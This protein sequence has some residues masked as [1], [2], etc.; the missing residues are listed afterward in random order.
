MLCG[1]PVLASTLTV[2]PTFTLRFVTEAQARAN[3][4]GIAYAGWRTY[5][6]GMPFA[7][8]SGSPE[9]EDGAKTRAEHWVLRQGYRVTDWADGEDGLIARVE[10]LSSPT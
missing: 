5:C 3:P 10:P 2:V 9:R 6:D 8:E 7:W 4:D 1:A